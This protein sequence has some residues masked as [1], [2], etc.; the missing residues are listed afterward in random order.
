MPATRVKTKWVG[1]NLHYQGTGKVVFDDDV[2]LAFGT[3]DDSEIYFDGAALVIEGAQVIQDWTAGFRFEDDIELSFGDNDDVVLNWDSGAGK[4]EMLPAADDTLWEIGN[5]TLSMDITIFGGTADH[6]IVFDA[7]ANLV[8]LDGVDFRLEDAD[9]LLFGDA[10]D[11]A[12]RWDGTDLDWL[13]L[14]NNTVMKFGNGTESFDLWIYGS[15]VGNYLLF[16]ASANSLAPVGAATIRT[17]PALADVANG[18]ALPVTVSG[19]IPIVTAGAETRTL[20]APT[21]IGQ[22]LLIYGKT[23][24]GACVI[25]CATTVN[26]AG[27]TIITLTNTGESVRLIAVEEGATIRWRCP[28]ADPTSILSGP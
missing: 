4:L 9:L 14:A 17:L 11:V 15:A 27:N 10:S 21:Y 12:L 19:Y 2:H 22:E 13:A 1:G 6:Q 25:T 23:L 8:S 3:G 7:S 18:A 28:V 20:A 5:G 16:D 24:V 26:E